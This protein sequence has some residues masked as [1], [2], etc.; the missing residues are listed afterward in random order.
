[1]RQ[2]SDL[3][4]LVAQGHFDLATPFFAA[5]LMFNQPGFD[6]DRVHF[7]YY[8]AGHMMYIHQPSLVEFTA[9]VRELITGR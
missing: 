2:N 3:Q 8:E 5:E 9:D 6:Q 4:V 7:K 1:M